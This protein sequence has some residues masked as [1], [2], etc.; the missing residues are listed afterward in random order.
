M[1]T[2]SEYFWL[3]PL[4]EKQE[5]S[6]KMWWWHHHHIFWGSGVCQKYTMWVLIGCGIKFCIQGALPLEIWVKTQGDMSKIW[7]KNVVFFYDKYVN[8]TIMVDSFYWNSIGSWI[9]NHKNLLLAR[10]II[11]P[12]LDAKFFLIFDPQLCRNH[13]YCIRETCCNKLTKPSC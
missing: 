5:I 1:S 7:T 10:F 11:R 13:W 2:H 4:P 8:S 6:E 9:P 3:S 12:I